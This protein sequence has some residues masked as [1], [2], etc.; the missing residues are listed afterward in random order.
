MSEHYNIFN[1]LNFKETAED[2]FL[3][4]VRDYYE[5]VVELV[6]K[7]EPNWEPNKD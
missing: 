6:K 7:W 3:K 1:V 4:V 2:D 5:L